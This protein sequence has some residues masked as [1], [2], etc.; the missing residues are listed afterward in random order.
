MTTKKST[1]SA[2]ITRLDSR[3]SQIDTAFEEIRN[4]APG[5]QL[6]FYLITHKPQP[7]SRG[8]MA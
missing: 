3:L 1:F 8:D 7:F 6:K 4:S 2:L 5:E